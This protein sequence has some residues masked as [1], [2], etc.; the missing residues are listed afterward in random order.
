[1]SQWIFDFQ[2]AMKTVEEMRVSGVN[3]N[4]K[5]YTTLVK[6]WARASM[7]EKA[8]ACFDEMKI[9]GL[10]PDKAAYHCLMTSL[11][12]RASVAE[13]YLRPGILSICREMVEVN[14]TVDLGTAVHWSK[15]LRKIE[16]SGGEITEAL[17]KTFPPSW[18]SLEVSE[19]GSYELDDSR[20]ED[21]DGDDD[22]NEDGRGD[23]DG[24][25]D[26]RSWF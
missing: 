11:L 9:S 4:L 13:G 3:P 8:L 21:Y 26:Y 10:Q 16:R 15:C 20:S 5:T 1:M 24:E 12:S 25:E 23:D 18:T 7:P 22:G 2:R 19:A 6:G 14:V 17:Q